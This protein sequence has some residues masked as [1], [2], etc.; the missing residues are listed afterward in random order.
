MTKIFLVR[1]GEADGNYYRRCQ[2]QQD[3]PLS[4]RGR[5]Q[6]EALRARFASI[7]IDAAYASDLQRAADTAAIASGLAV[8][9]DA[10]LR[11]MCVGIWEGRAWGNIAREY[12]E[13]FRCFCYEPHL[14]AVE[15]GETAEELL[16]RMEEALLEIGAR[17][18]GESV[19]VGSHGRAIR[20]VL[21]RLLGVPSERIGEVKNPENT[22]IAHIVY[23]NGALRLERYNDIDHLPQSLRTEGMKNWWGKDGFSD[24]NLRFEPF[25]PEQERKRYLECYR[26]AWRVAHG[27]LAGFDELACWLG[28][29]YRS[30]LSPEALQSVWKGEEF[31]GYVALDEQRGEHLGYGWVSF[32]Y[33]KEEFRGQGLGIQ[34]IG[35]AATRFRAL[36]RGKLRLCAA[37]KNPALGF[38]EHMGF[39]RCGTERGALEELVLLEKEL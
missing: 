9:E 23:E 36:G 37:Q 16:S 6:V 24:T 1:H 17:H 35:A 18:E 7:K 5:E 29:S 28:A 34:L 15:G 25:C 30:S 12:P 21:A 32:L 22:A 3:V 27:S 38:Y 33:L 20:A 31:A 11:E 8:T 4:R 13:A 39:R 10:R 2:G 19:L 14:F 26:D